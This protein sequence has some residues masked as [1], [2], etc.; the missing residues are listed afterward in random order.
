MPLLIVSFVVLLTGFALAE[1]GGTRAMEEAR[2]ALQK[3][4]AALVRNETVPVFWANDGQSAVY[5]FQLESGAREWRQLNLTTGEITQIEKKP[6]EVKKGERKRPGKKGTKPAL[7]TRR[8]E[9]SYDKQHKVEVRDDAVLLNGTKAAAALPDGWKWE[10]KPMWSPDSTRF[11]VWKNTRFP[12]REV[13][14]VRSSP[15]EQLQ[16][17]HF[18][19][20]YPKPGDKLNIAHPVIFFVDDREPIEIDPELIRNPFDLRKFGWRQ[21]SQRFVFEFIE[22]GFGTFR[23]VEVQTET[24][25]QRALINEV[26][27]KFVFVFGNTYRRD[28]KG[29]AEILWLSERDGWNHLYLI[30]GQSGEV[31]RQLTKGEWIVREVIDVDEAERFAV[32]RMGGFDAGQDPYH[33]HFSRID[34]DS[35]EMTRLT[36]GDG[37]H[38]LFWAPD[39]ETYLDRWSRVDQ[40]PVHEIR[41]FSDGASVATLA[42]ASGLD[43]LEKAGWQRPQRFVAKDR[44]DEFDIHGMILRPADFD[45]EKSYPIIEAIYAGPHGSFTPKSW[46]LQHGAMS[47][48]ANAGFIV[49][50]LDGLG[51][52]HRGKKFQQVAYQ[53]LI[54]SGFPDRV[55]WIREAAKQ[56][57]QM[58]LSRVGIYGGSAGGQSTLAGLLTHPEFYKA[59]AADCGCHD[60]RMDKIWWNEQ[61]MDWPVGPEYEANANVT[62]IDAL[63]GALLLTVGELDKNVDPASTLQVVNALIKADKDF[64]FFLVPGAGHGVGES[65]YLRRKRIEF[66]QRHLGG[67]Q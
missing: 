25:E 61:W 44:N 28:L 22:R 21:D 43:Q 60:N 57:P 14:Y 37:T 9:I 45:P 39:G 6:A 63:Q 41:R 42:E 7:E 48:M 15:D 5:H 31:I 34:L 23:V 29:G 16:P 54:D 47:A 52:N 32:I 64:E 4:Y 35:G 1:H 66:F 24:R 2:T 59:G 10:G 55:K 19:N 26:D 18:T 49:V 12:V 17:E 3:E 11:V 8:G 56:V 30:D 50:K 53:N 13:H 40:P 27:E 20:R 67:P 65:P 36:D 38:E 58:D 33:S 46:R 51:T 62:H